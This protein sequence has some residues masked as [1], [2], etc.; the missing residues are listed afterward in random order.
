MTSREQNIIKLHNLADELG[1][2]YSYL[3]TY[4]DGIGGEL[5]F[6]Y[7]LAEYK[8]YPVNHKC[9]FIIKQWFFLCAYVNHYGEFIVK[10]KI[11]FPGFNEKEH[12]KSFEEVRQ[13]II[14]YMRYSKEHLV[15][16]KLERIKWDFQ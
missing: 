6:T 13:Y 5:V 2:Y 8:Q 10:S 1:L 4:S 16:V 7:N 9:R 3:N 11:A 15:D 12:F 14:D